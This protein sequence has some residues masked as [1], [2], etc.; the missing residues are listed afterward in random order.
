M[1]EDIKMD[2]K[3]R[4]YLRIR[5]LIYSYGIKSGLS[6]SV[7]RFL[8]KLC[9]AV[10]SPVDFY[11]RYFLA[12]TITRNSNLRNF[13]PRDKGYATFGAGELSFLKP[14]E[15]VAR[16]IYETRAKEASARQKEMHYCELID[17]Q[18]FKDYPELL[19]T[20]TSPEVVAIISD[21]LGVV[22]RL[23]RVQIWLSTP[24]LTKYQPDGEVEEETVV[25]NRQVYKRKDVSAYHL[26]KP[27]EHMVYLFILL[28]DVAVENGP[29]VFIP[30][31][32]SDTL[33]KKINYGKNLSARLPP[34]SKNDEARYL[35][36]D[37]ITVTGKAGE[38]IFVD[39]AQCLHKSSLCTEGER[40]LVV[41]SYR[42]PR[43]YFQCVQALNE[44]IR[45]HTKDDNLM[46]NLVL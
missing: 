30:K 11:R 21:Y 28:T 45:L 13:I 25:V 1:K 38:G 34:V 12:K 17:P 3:E 43:P 8:I 27:E 10:F 35:K 26:D 18:D 24:E 14:L 44:G 41:I 37:A 31:K 23:Q 22:P 32:M 16:K 6:F 33:L 40:A 9:N 39:V 5:E 2:L 29:F 4:I 46:Q 36:D 42:S 20:A 15:R 7:I 19:E